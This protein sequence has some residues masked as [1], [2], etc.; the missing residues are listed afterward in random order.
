MSKRHFKYGARTPS[1][2][3]SLDDLEHGGR[4][5]RMQGGTLSDGGLAAF[6]TVGIRGKDSQLNQT[7]L[8]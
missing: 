3:P 8:A 5:R 6:E 7:H 1:P 4:A 2:D